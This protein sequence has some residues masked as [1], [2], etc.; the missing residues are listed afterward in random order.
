VAPSDQT[1]SS[2]PEFPR[3]LRVI[4]QL[5]RG[6]YGVVHLCEDR[7][8]NQVAVKHVRH[9]AKH[10]KSILREIR[11]L[12]RLWHENLLHL[13]DFPAVPSPSFED[14]FLVLPYLPADLHKVIQ[15][16]QALT[17]KHVQVIMC[18]ILRALAY[19]HAAGVAHRDLKPANI[20]LTADCKLKVCDFGLARGD[21]PTLEGDEEEKEACGVLTEYVVTRWYRAPEVMLLP[22]QYTSAVDL[23]SV[24]CILCE[25]LGRKAL[26]PGKNHIDMVVRVAQVLGSPSDEELSWLP[27]ES[28]AYRFLRKVCPQSAGIDLSQKYPLASPA[29]LDLAK[30][31]LRWDPNARLSAVDAQ[32]HDYLRSYIPKEA[33]I[34][35]E[36]F[37]WTFDGFKPTV[38]AVRDRL[39]QEC[40]R[41]HSEIL[42]RDR[43]LGRAGDATPV[44]GRTT[45][46]RTSGYPK[47]QASTPVLQ[48]RSPPRAPSVVQSALQQATNGVH[49]ARSLQPAPQQVAQTSLSARPSPEQRPQPQ[50][51][52]QTSLSARTS[53]QQGSQPQTVAPAVAHRH[54]PP[55]AP[56]TRLRP[57]G[58]TSAANTPATVQRHL[59]PT[60]VRESSYT[61]V[62][63]RTSSATRSLTPQRGP[64]GIR[65]AVA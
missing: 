57:S 52:A 62:P 65:A 56:S 19:L 59:G 61:K 22:K 21:M 15:S 16:R 29:C 64:I 32:A 45:S 44:A 41:F 13:I 7:A 50:Q 18:Q 9:A 27:K 20:L 17:E 43:N 6:A 10:G 5:G 40:A 33:P 55:T 11:L 48:T 37:D 23:W 34:P 8:G 4:R 53:P 49:S 36:P 26:F 51:V 58:S 12:A 63:S 39:Y 38:E 30:S 46:P 42:D 14:V 28:D 35:P 60:R 3:H 31:L 54:S 24:G 2:A 25:V 1:S 47:N